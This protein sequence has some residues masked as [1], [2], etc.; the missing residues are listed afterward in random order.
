[1]KIYKYSLPVQGAYT[2][3]LPEWRKLLRV[4]GQGELVCLW[5]LVDDR[6]DAAK[7]AVGFQVFFTGE[8]VDV[9]P[10]LM[11]H[12]VATL[13]FLGTAISHEGHI[14]SHVFEVEEV[15]DV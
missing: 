11:R 5:Y 6:D 12:G 4:E 7:E 13:E 3:S 15:S 2:L 14:L 10:A 9:D 1:M 8:E